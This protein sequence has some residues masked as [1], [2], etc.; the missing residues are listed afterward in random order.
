MRIVAGRGLMKRLKIFLLS[1]SLAMMFSCT[2]GSTPPG[3]S[4]TTQ[5]TT[6]TP[7]FIP[8]PNSYSSALTITISSAT[9]GASIFYTTDGTPPSAASTLYVGPITVSATTTVKVIAQALGY[10]DST[11]A[12]GIYT[13]AGNSN[14]DGLHVAGNKI[15][16]VNGQEVRI[17]G[18]NRS[19]TEYACIQGWG[20]F[21]GPNDAASIQA[22]KSWKANAVRIPLNED[23][24]LG[25]NDVL[26]QYGGASY[27]QAIADYVNTIKQQGLIPIL[28]LHWSAPGSTQAVSQQPMPDR[29]HSPAFWTQVAQMF[30]GNSSV[31]F[32]LFN[33]PFPDANQDTAA[34]WTCWR[35][36]GVC[37]GATYT[38]AGMQ[39]L[40]TAVR[41]TGATNIIL[42]GG[43]EY[44]NSLTGW[45]AH[46]PND[47]L[48]NLA[49][50]WH[51]YNFN[52][53]ADVSCYNSNTG[54]VLAAVPV[55][56]TE[57]GEDDCQGVFISTLTG[58]LDN[59]GGSYLA[60]VWDTWGSSC[61]S[62]SLI[63]DY[64]GTPNG[65]YGQ[66]YKDH[67]TALNP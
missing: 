52:M 3:E 45:L 22:I 9:N 19:G 39:E 17:H 46:K 43:V 37:P 59:N 12:T 16:N 38:V 20:I 5:P 35:D 66:T 27:Q 61:G 14:I 60:W 26:P 50:A 33:E 32:E 28:E 6:A 10:A 41:G 21:D 11:V 65:A 2:S 8:L 4:N 34:A 51:V 64:N 25:I 67:L 18:V 13:I 23:C 15:Y 44:S 29:D 42:L 54:P 24:W 49:A 48:G 56:T 31:I 57:I 1:L 36:G 40:V 30:K 58:W 7:T 53:C 63:S 62:I 55:V 47:P